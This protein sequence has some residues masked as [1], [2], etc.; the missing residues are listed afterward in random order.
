MQTWRGAP[1]EKMQKAFKNGFLMMSLKRSEKIT[2]VDLKK[3]VEKNF[4]DFLQICS[5]PPQEN[6]KFCLL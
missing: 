1:A 3:N 2:L 6:W 4:E 5:P